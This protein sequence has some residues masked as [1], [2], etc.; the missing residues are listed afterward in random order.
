ME[1][2]EPMP[3]VDLGPDCQK[4]NFAGPT[5]RGT[6]SVVEAPRIDGV[7]TRGVH[8]VLQTTVD[9]RQQTG[10]LYSY[11]AH[12]GTYQVVVT[13]NPLVVPDK[14]PA[15]VDVRRAEDLLVAAVAAIRDAPDDEQQ[16][17]G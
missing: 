3:S 17:G 13:A 5:L 12:F 11:V 8:R 14:P 4:V 1:T 16:T 10:Q 15:P 9:G 2:S 6:V 7:Q